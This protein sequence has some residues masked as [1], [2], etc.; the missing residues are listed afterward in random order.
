MAIKMMVQI[1]LT[2]V[3]V[4]GDDP[5]ETIRQAAFFQELPPSCPLCSEP[6]VFTYREAKG[7]SWWGLRCLGDTS[8]A[9]EFG[10]KKEGGALF[11]KAKEEWH[12]WM[13]PSGQGG[14]SRSMADDGSPDY[15]REY[16][17]SL[18]INLPGDPGYVDPG[19][20]T[21]TWEDIGAEGA[22]RGMTREQV[23]S[24]ARKVAGTN[25]LKEVTPAGRD[26]ILGALRTARV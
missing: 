13:K 1:G 2:T 17:P 12:E 4:E 19:P 3:T 25:D 8:H 10:Q 16:D 23:A 5:K 21:T 9:S 6:I 20:A 14:S 7:F 22:R 26:K 11:Y 15:P 24:F 18:D